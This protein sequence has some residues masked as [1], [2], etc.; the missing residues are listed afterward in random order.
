MGNRDRP[1]LDRKR[2][3][4]PSPAQR[5]RSQS[6]AQNGPSDVPTRSEPSS[7]APAAEATIIEG[8]K[9]NS[10]EN[11]WRAEVSMMAPVSTSAAGNG[12]QKMLSVRGPQRTKKETAE[13]DAEQMKQAA[14][15]G[16]QRVE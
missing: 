10:G 15:Q 4:S 16:H 12:R 11:F 9:A 13:S 1:P 2:R 7:Y 3:R 14:S 6:P 5:Q 8:Q